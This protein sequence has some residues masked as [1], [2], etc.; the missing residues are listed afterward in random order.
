MDCHSMFLHFFDIDLGP[1]GRLG[2][3]LLDCQSLLAKS[4]TFTQM[5]QICST[6]TQAQ[7]ARPNREKHAQRAMVAVSDRPRAEQRDVPV[8]PMSVLPES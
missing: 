1:S 7:K 4:S 8:R 5:F 2:I 6:T 3:T